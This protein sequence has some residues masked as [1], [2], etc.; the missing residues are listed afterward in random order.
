MKYGM[1]VILSILILS[2]VFI[3]T[4]CDNNSEN[5]TATEPYQIDITE[6]KATIED[7]SDSDD[8][9]FS[10][11]SFN[12]TNTSDS[13]LSTIYLYTRA[14]DNEGNVL[15]TSTACV[16]NLKPNQSGWTDDSIFEVYM[17]NISRI[18][19]VGFDVET[20]D[21]EYVERVYEDFLSFD[22]ANIL[23]TVNK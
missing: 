1:R 2:F 12:V 8:G 19:I 16:E 13:E 10:L 22:S 18:E 4:G 14:L 7:Y 20:V 5:K 17:D 9:V 21:G 15:D 3:M 6:T 11:I 23:T